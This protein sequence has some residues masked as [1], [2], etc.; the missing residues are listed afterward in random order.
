MSA[1]EGLGRRPRALAVA[2]L[3][4]VCAG[5][6]ALA[7][8]ALSALEDDAVDARFSLRADAPPSELAV[9]AVDDVTFSDLR[10]QWPLPRS[11]YADALER[12]KA[13]GAAQV[14][15][16]VQFTEPT[17]EKEDF[18]LYD[19]I[20]AFGGAVLATSES[21]ERGRTNV[22]GGDEALAEIGSR[23]AAANLPDSRGG[24]VRRVAPRIGRLDSL[25]VAVAERAGRRVD[26]RAFEAG[27]AWIDF[28]GGPGTVPTV[29]LT[30]LLRRRFDPSLLRG[31]IVVVG[32]SAPTVGDVHA[33]ST[34]GDGSPMAGPEVQA[35]AIWT[36]L[37]GLPLRSA[38]GWVDLL[39]V[40]GLGLLAP[41]V[42]ARFGVLAAT[43]AALVLGAAF[44][45]GAHAA[46]LAGTMVTVTPALLALLV[47]AVATVVASHLG[48]SRERRRIAQLNELLDARVRERT[49]EI[50]DT[51]LEIIGRLGRAVE[52]R[53]G[54]TGAHITRI[55]SLCH[56]LALAAGL[57]AAEAEE[58]RHASVM[59]DIGK[60]AVPD[61][62]LYKPGR[63]D[64]EERAIMQTH[65][66]AGGDILAG[67]RIPVIR[68]AE[69]IARTH[70]ERWDGGGYPA[71]LAGEDIPL[72]GR[73]CAI[74]DVF[75]A[76]TSERPYKHAWPVAEALAEIRD[77][78]GR[79][80]DPRLVD[81]F[82]AMMSAPDAGAVP[83]LTAAG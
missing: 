36:V 62:I 4:A 55:S 70:H 20:G 10:E 30:D 73:I 33:T 76:L 47:S 37:H 51:Q 63:F 2:A 71:G 16:D 35:N 29:S 46:F 7:T 80:F 45:A 12:L 40:L 60:I 34:T 68:T 44:L 52:S 49:Q 65:A 77:Q 53:D 18:A 75:D 19:A 27:G 78:R 6:L 9:V 39:A 25:A 22:L 57:S 21:D 13:A 72:A 23:A 38:P 82:L 56:D 43:G 5:L 11:I 8:G 64:D 32:A 79:Q 54:E 28:R 42:A 59:H 48:E 67:S 3:L 81:L 58:I 31:R 1:G 17:E 26:R 14:V 83:E 41:L 61:R 50:S 69:T 24:V 66:A 74:A 15:F